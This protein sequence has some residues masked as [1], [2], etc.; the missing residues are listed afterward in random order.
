MS[1]VA[2]PGVV[3]RPAAVV[4]VALVYWTRSAVPALSDSRIATL[5]TG[6]SL[7]DDPG[8]YAVVPPLMHATGVTDPALVVW[9]LALAG[10]AVAV[11]Y[12]VRRGVVPTVVLV[13]TAPVAMGAGAAYWMPAWAVW[14]AL[15]ASPAA[16]GVI[17]IAV[18]AFRATAGLPALAWAFRR[19]WIGVL[20]VAGYVMLTSL[21]PGHVFW[22]TAFVG[23]GWAPNPWGLTYADEVG[24]AAAPGIAYATPAYEAALRSLVIAHVLERPDYIAVELLSKVSECVKLAVPWVLVVPLLVTRRP[25]LLV[26]LAL[27][28]VS[29]LLAVPAPMFTTGWVAACA[30]VAS[31]PVLWR[32]LL[33][34]ARPHFEDHWVGSRRADRERHAAIRREGELVRVRTG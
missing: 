9:W 2:R 21:L 17:G 5:P 1:S 12:T 6:N 31:D 7:A 22:H 33:S 27:T 8:L 13:L 3:L 23:L 28:L 25:A 14:M 18:T 26:P 24:M 15:P 16:S 4:L 34:R 20:A 29:P 30:Y 11:A 32:E 19:W 10:Y